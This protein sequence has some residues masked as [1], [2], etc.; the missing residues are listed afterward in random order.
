[1]KPNL[2]TYTPKR[3]LVCQL[4]QIGDVLLST[5]SIR[6]LAERYPD[7]QIDV[8]TEKKC[9]PVLENNP[10]IAAIKSIDKAALKNPIKALAYYAHV[11]RGNYD[12]IVDF[13]Q[14]PR[15]KWV[16]RFSNAPVKLTYTPPW[17]NKPTYTHWV[18]MEYGYA[19]KC[20]ASVL[21]PLDIEWNGEK[22][23]LW[24]TDKERTFATDFLEHSGIKNSLFITVDPSHRR[25]TRRWPSRHFAELIRLL[26]KHHP[27]LHAVIL[28]GPGEKELAEKVAA[29]AGKRAFAT[30]SMLSL[31]EMAAIQERA[32]MHLGN[33]SAPRHFAVAVDTPSLIIQGATGTGWGF[34]SEEHVSATKKL[35]C[36][37]CN[38]NSC[39]FGTRECLEEFYPDDIL[40]EALRILKFGLQKKT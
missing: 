15:C 21:K 23:E 39:R 26:K 16:T 2:T 33:C 11:G 9:V 7:A 25:E 18:D 8:L 20:K 27:S 4:R 12:L 19:A 5:P 14:L 1:M 37:P 36:Y 17:Y 30:N 28:Y 13:Q 35:P 24:L 32:S 3:I 38:K 10:R 6:L 40:D 31:R 34:P 29:Q 22:P